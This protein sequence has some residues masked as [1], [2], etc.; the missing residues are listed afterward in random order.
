MAVQPAPQFTLEHIEGHPVSLS[1]F[2][3]RTVVVALSG[4]H[5]AQ[6]MA[7]GIGELRRHY[8]HEQLPILAVAEM[9]GIPRP[10][11]AIAKRK[12]KSGYKDAVKTASE[13]LQAAGKPVPPGSELV[14]MLPDWSGELASGFGIADVDRE[15]AMVLV[16]PEGNVLGHGRGAAA[17]QQIRTLLA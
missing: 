15:A 2:R 3:G 13:G 1:D 4:R 5:S 8:D 12:L 11:Q 10:A 7:Q 14:I 6:E 9:G 17:A 16:D